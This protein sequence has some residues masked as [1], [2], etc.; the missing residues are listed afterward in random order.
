MRESCVSTVALF[1][2]GSGGGQKGESSRPGLGTGPV[3]LF[4]PFKHRLSV[5]QTWSWHQLFPT[6]SAHGRGGAGG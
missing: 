6:D 1:R 5:I 2:G 3:L 4:E